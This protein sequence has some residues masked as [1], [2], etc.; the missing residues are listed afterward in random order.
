M[1]K[2]QRGGWTLARVG[3]QAGRRQD[4]VVALA[5]GMGEG[6]YRDG[7]SGRRMPQHQE[8]IPLV[9]ADGRQETAVNGGPKCRILGG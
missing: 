6:Q 8:P 4:G 9:F 5:G 2:T 7:S 3:P 1:P